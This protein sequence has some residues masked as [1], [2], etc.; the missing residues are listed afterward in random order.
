M[1]VLLFVGCCDMVCGC[2]CLLFVVCL[3]LFR[4]GVCCLFVFVRL[5]FGGSCVVACLH[6]VCCLFDVV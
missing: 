4:L 6:V 2:C 5:F 1:F 3:L